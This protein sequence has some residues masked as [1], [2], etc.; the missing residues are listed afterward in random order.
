MPFDPDV[1]IGVLALKGGLYVL[2]RDQ[3]AACRYHHEDG[4]LRTGIGAACGCREHGK[5]EHG[6]DRRAV[7]FLWTSTRSTH[8]TQGLPSVMTSGLPVM[9]TRR[10]GPPFS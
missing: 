3:E 6:E 2:E 4:A 1:D 10:S 9:T 7:H 5:D 8:F